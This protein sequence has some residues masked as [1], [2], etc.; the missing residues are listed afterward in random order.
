MASTKTKRCVYCGEEKPL[1]DF[2]PTAKSKAHQ[3]ADGTGRINRC[4]TCIG[5]QRMQRQSRDVEV[6]IR[7]LF[8]KNKSGRKNKF[9][10]AIQPEDL[11]ELWEQQEGKC[12]LSGVYMTHHVDRGHRKDFN[13]SIDRIRSTEGYIKNNVQLVCQR[14]NT[15]KNDLDEASLYWWVKNIYDFSCD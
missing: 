13:V 4:T 15:I 14:V 9:E 8:T 10:W 1:T 5:S 6:Y 7:D 12:A 11:L 3:S 2:S